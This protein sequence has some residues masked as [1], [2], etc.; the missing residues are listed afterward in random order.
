MILARRWPSIG[1][2]RLRFGMASCSSLPRSNISPR[3]GFLP[4]PLVKECQHLLRIVVVSFLKFTR[5]LGDE[6]LSSSIKD[7]EC[8]Q[9]KARR[10]LITGIHLFVMPLV[11]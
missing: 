6:S 7:D 3:S 11:Y 4:R 2:N 5:V 1:C 10:G 8:R 9:T